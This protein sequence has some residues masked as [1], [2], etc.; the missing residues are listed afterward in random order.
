MKN[1]IF[2]FH[3]YNPLWGK[4]FTIM[5]RN[6]SENSNFDCDNVNYGWYAKLDPTQVLPLL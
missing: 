1:H 3:T 5:L 6:K 4:N 2:F